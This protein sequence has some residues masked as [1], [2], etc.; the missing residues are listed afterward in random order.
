LLTLL[1]N[2]SSLRARTIDL[3]VSNQRFSKD[4]RREKPGLQFMN[5]NFLE[6]V[7][8]SGIFQYFPFPDLYA[9]KEEF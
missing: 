2:I 8:S 9:L 7:I 4:G 1:S 5:Q 3:K 6:I